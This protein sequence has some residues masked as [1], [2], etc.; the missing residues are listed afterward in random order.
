M[1]HDIQQ[2]SDEG[3]KK[4]GQYAASPIPENCIIL[5]SMNFDARRKWYKSLKS[6]VFAVKIETPFD[7]QIPSWISSFAQQREKNISTDASQ[8][9]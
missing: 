2:L 3:I 5:I 6:K 4:I 7:N 1:I 8:A 9:I